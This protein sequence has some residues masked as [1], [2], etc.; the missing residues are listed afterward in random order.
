MI[1]RD[2]P[3]T[4]S[5]RFLMST[6]QI[7]DVRTFW[8]A[9]PCGSTLS[10]KADRKAYFDEHERL[11]YTLEPHIPKVAQFTAYRDRDVLEIGCG[12]GCDGL[13]FARNGARYVGVDLTPAAAAMTRERFDVYGVPGEFHV[14]NAESLPF[15]DA[16]FDHVYSFGVIHHSPH[17]ET[18]VDEIRRV[19]RPGGTATLMVYNRTSINYYVEIMCLRKLFRLMLRPAF[20]PRVTA[21]VLGFSREK[22]KRHRALMLERPHMPNEQWISMNTDGPDCPL[23]KVYSAAEARALFA[24][25]AE[26]RTEVRHFDRGHWSFL[27]KLM[28]DVLVRWIGRRWGW[29]RMVYARKS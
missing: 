29:H 23:A 20:M 28:P 1:Q 22:L 11:R 26:V 6:A 5:R 16:R 12:I 10:E 3:E 18:I 4:D 19:L 24:R 8:N 13:Q 17:T 14:T 21:A 9:N 27:G 25:F 15:D 2:G 7:E